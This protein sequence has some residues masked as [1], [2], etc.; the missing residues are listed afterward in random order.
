MKHQFWFAVLLVASTSCHDDGITES[1]STPADAFA[2]HL[3]NGFSNTPVLVS[4]DGIRI[5]ADTVST[6]YALAVAAVIPVQ[7][8][9]G[10][11]QLSVTIPMRVSKD[12]LF[13]IED[14]LYTAVHYDSASAT[15]GY[16]FQRTPFY[17]R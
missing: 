2:I 6:G 3:Q 11:H 5:F 10:P 1:Q 13:V 9:R 16:H 17:Y 4:V 7:V 8:N 15:I 12:T 14:T